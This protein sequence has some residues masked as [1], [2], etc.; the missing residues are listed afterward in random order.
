VTITAEA[1][2][3]VA[4]GV[5]A[6]WA[7]LTAIERFPEWLRESGI[8]R[9]DR[10]TE[11]TTA[12]GTALRIEQRLAGRT[13]VLEGVVTAWEPPAHFGFRARHPDGIAIEVDAALA[14]DAATTWLRWRIQIGLPLRLRLF[15]SVAAPEVRR[16]AA[17]DLFGLKR[18]LEQVAG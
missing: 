9:V 5:D 13:S 18:R 15:E 11:A 17:A 7:E 10:L 4:R 16:A 1:E 6:V 12:L 8:I 3:Q 2:V 14:P